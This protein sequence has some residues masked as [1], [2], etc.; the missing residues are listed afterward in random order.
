ME[1]TIYQVA[2]LLQG[3]VAGNGEE[4]INTIA[5]IQE[6]KPGAITFLANPKYEKYIYTT[7]ASAVIV[8]RDFIAENPIN[9]TLI[10]VDDPYSSFTKL[11]EEYDRIT[12]YTK[13]GIEE[14]SFIAHDATVGEKIYRGAFS[15]IGAKTKIGHNV[16]I[17]PQTYI[18][19]NVAIGD[20]CIFFS[21]VKIYAGSVIG[22]NCIIHAGT[23]I[24]S[25]GFGFAPQEDGTYRKI[26]QDRKSVV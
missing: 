20:N 14:P 8:S 17:Y 19:D 13:S 15:Y 16:K 12:N 18:G 4:K 2:A 3:E 26:P 1:F 7:G 10:K 21:G 25:D 11:L 24:G 6:A 5:K 22:N 9:T 23:V